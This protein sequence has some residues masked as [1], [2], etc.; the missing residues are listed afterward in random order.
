MAPLSFGAKLACLQR[1]C[2]ASVL[3]RNFFPPQDKKIQAE[4]RVLHFPPRL[5]PSLTMNCQPIS[6]PAPPRDQLL[7]Y[8]A[9]KPCPS[10][11]FTLSDHYSRMFRSLWIGPIGLLRQPMSAGEQPL[12]DASA[13]TYS[14]R[15]LLGQKLQNRRHPHKH[16]PDGGING[17]ICWGGEPESSFLQLWF[18]SRGSGLHRGRPCT[19]Q[20]GYL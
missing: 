5:I 10:N 13:G 3:R 2:D 8:F 7:L 11:Y 4:V 9:L 15:D 6:Q 20:I 12:S 18:Y 17:W 19:P 14:K 16:Y 1:Y